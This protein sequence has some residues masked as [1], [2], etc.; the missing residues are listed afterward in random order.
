M[1]G[2]GVLND[3]LTFIFEKMDLIT[4][5][6]GLFFWQTI[7][8]LILIFL[9]AKFAWKPILGSVQKREQSINDALAS[10]ENARKEMQNL[11]ADNEKLLKEARLERENILKEAREIK[12]KIITDATDEAQ[13][14]AD[15]IV[16][17]AQETIQN[18]KMS[19]MADIKNQV[20]TLSIEIAEKVVR[21][22]LSNEKEQLGLVE[23]MLSE[24]TL[25]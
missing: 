6:F 7:V 19:A 18:E 23:E 3:V 1:V 14:K 9:M 8:F 17:Q 25:N 22:Q 21:K 10:A 5:E 24:V 12:S 11:Q 13:Q 2:S 4:P 20:A 16:A 15:R